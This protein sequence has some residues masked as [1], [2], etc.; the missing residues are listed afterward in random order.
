MREKF[1]KLKFNIGWKSAIIIGVCVTLVIVDL[2]TKIF[3]EKYGW[4]FTVI[5]KIIEVRS[6][7]RNPGC[8][9]SFLEEAAW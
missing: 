5:P 1:K 8:A 7:S 6:G 3:E 4:N 9:F 2:L